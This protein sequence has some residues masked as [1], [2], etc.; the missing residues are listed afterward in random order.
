MT[1]PRQLTKINSE[2]RDVCFSLLN[3]I[4]V[5]NFVVMVTLE[6]KCLIEEGRRRRRK[7]KVIEH[8]L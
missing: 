5:I 7:I 1:T 8:E 3:M 6:P 4:F 2:K